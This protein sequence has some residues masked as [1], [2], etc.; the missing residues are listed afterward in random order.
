MIQVPGISRAPT[1]R[2]SCPSRSCWSMVKALCLSR[3]C[4]TSFSRSPRI[5]ALLQAEAI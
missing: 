4:S 2:A 1:C 5:L 3:L